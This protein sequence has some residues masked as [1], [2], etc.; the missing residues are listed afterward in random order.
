MTKIAIG[1]RALLG[2][3]AAA[4]GVTV[5]AA[6]GI[7]AHAAPAKTVVKIGTDFPVEHPGSVRLAR[8]GAEGRRAFQGTAGDAGVPVRPAG[9]RNRHVLATPLRRDRVHD[10]VRRRAADRRAA[11][12]RHQ[13]RAVRLQELRPRVVVDGRRPRPIY[14]RA[15]ST[16]TACSRWQALGQRLPQH[17]QQ[18]ADQH[19]R[20]SQGLQDPACR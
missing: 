1:R 8:G 9:R 5:L 13:R 4:A 10:D 19:R 14:L 20:R 6:P 2:G 7:I 3:T 18:R 17:H 15:K 11:T 12:C 16:G